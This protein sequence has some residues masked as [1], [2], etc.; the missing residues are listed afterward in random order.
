LESVANNVANLNTYGYK[1]TRSLFGDLLYEA[2]ALGTTDLQQVGTGTQVSIQNLINQASFEYTENVTDLAINGQG[3]FTVRTPLE[4]GDAAGSLYY[5]RAGQFVVD[6]DGYL[7]N[8]EGYYLQGFAV[9]DQGQVVDTT[10]QDLQVPTEI[11]EGASTSLVELGVNLDASDEDT[12]AQSVE[13]DPLDSSTYNYGMS[14]EVYDSD[15]TQHNLV[16]FY[17]RL[18]SYSGAAPADSQSV[19]KASLFENID[20]SYYANPTYPDDTFFLH[21]DTDGIWRA[22]PGAPSPPAT[23]IPQTAPC[24]WSAPR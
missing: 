5:T 18:S 10:L 4:T 23:P 19:W 1:S 8:Q 6:G 22:S 2:I 20:G 17:Q 12:H 9:D 11:D 14:F 24:S 15:R 13:I 16:V 21:F 3:F 7:V